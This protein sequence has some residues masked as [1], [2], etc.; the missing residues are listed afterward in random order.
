MDLI[1]KQMTQIRILV[2]CPLLYGIHLETS[3][4]SFMSYLRLQKDRVQTI[5]P[6]QKEISSQTD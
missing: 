4:A 1:S 3:Q 2:I 6:A 5:T